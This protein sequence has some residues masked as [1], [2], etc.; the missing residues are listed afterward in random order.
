MYEILKEDKDLCLP[1][2]N[3]PCERIEQTIEMMV[4]RNDIFPV[5]DK[6]PMEYKI[7]D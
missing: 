1:P 3:I 2:V 5:G 4:E 7:V 6:E